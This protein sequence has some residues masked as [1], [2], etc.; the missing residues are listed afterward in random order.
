MKILVIHNLYQS[1][2]GEDVA[3]RAEMRML[4]ERGHTVVRYERTNDELR[5]SNGFSSIVTGFETVWA[6]RSFH[7]V[8]TLIATEKPDVAHFHNTLPL[9]SPSAYYACAEADIPVVQTAHNLRLLCPG[10]NLLRNGLVCEG[11]VG[12]SAK[13]PAV[14]H[15]CYRQSRGATLAVISMLAAHNAIGTWQRKV[16]L[17]LALTEFARRKFIEGGLPESRVV[18]KPNCVDPDPGPEGKRSNYAVYV[19]RLSEEKGI[20]TLIGAWKK[21]SKRIPLRVAGTGPLKEDVL[22]GLAREPDFTFEL[23]GLLPPRE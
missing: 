12:R 4:I 13:W 17:Y 16:G 5:Q 14:A 9:V 19:G 18:V 1:S 6:S 2:G 22:R 11:C 21:L 20:L 3:V 7:D 15:A 10:A 23:L 8:A